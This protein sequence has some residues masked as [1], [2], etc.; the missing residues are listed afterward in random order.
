[1]KAGK[2]EC[3]I[4]FF[5]IPGF[6]AIFD[7]RDLLEAM[8]FANA[9]LGAIGTVVEECNGDIDKFTGDGFLA[10]FGVTGA[11]QNHSRNACI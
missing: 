2:F 4:L 1:M 8:A 10:H 5:D 7:E 9:V 11:K 3:T 6:T